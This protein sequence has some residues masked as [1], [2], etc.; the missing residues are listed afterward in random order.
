MSEA[1]P[2]GAAARP[3]GGA[4]PGGSER[5]AG[6]APPGG[7]PSAATAPSGAAASLRAAAPPLACG[8]CLRRSWLLAR[9]AGRLEVAFRRRRPVRDVLALDD[10]RLVRGL[11]HDQTGAILA[12]LERL[13]GAT[14][15][16]DAAAAGLDVVCR[17]DAAY[18]SRLR[19]DRSAPAVL[20]IA[21]RPGEGA[22]RLI[23]L[24]GDGT[25][26]VAVVGTRQSSP[27]GAEVA[28]ALGR[29]LSAAGITVVS[30]L[31]LGIDSAAHTGAVEGGGRTIAV[32]AGGADRPYPLRKR[33]LYERIRG[34]G[35]VVSE[36]PPGFRP[37]RWAFPARNRTIAGLADATI[38][39]EAAGRSGSLI[40]AELAL[41]LGRD[42]G[43]VPGPVLSW[44][45]AGTNALLRDGATVIRD[46]RDVLDLVLGI[47]AAA[48]LAAR[49]ATAPAPAPPD[50]PRGLRGL[51]AA[52]E[53]GGDAPAR[54][55]AGG[56]DA[57][58]AV[59][60]GLTELELLGLVRRAPGG[61]YVRVI[62]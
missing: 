18:P 32:L 4:A 35:A 38:V 13:R 7:A 26:V 46:A 51:L 2:G 19:E 39:V 53:D 1:A 56:G 58:A 34:C 22:A 36:M 50:L 33:A 15:R 59:R 21:A 60:A 47:D 24:A 44:R 17:H 8:D 52:V 41:D 43:A 28:R 23:D 30:G 54:L 14:L 48:A 37:F 11:A 45:S 62:G 40:T 9:L 61:R 27:D 3:G 42:V 10:E 29:G 5:P 31:A 55:A 49:V 20:Y 25:P 12:E 16:A 57:A 6:A